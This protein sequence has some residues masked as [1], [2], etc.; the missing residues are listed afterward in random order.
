M[1]KLLSLLAI[2]FVLTA[3]CLNTNYVFS[4]INFISKVKSNLKTNLKRNQQKLNSLLYSNHNNEFENSLVPNSNGFELTNYNSVF[5]KSLAYDSTNLKLTSTL[6]NL[7]NYD[8]K[9]HVSKTDIYLDKVDYLKMHSIVSKDK[10]ETLI[11][12][13]LVFLNHFYNDQSVGFNPNGYIASRR[14]LLKTNS[15]DLKTQSVLVLQNLQKYVKDTLHTANNNHL[16]KTNT[17][18]KLSIG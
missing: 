7:I 8:S 10:K 3:S 11:G 12:N 6:S 14:S 5:L 13:N 17:V 15:T 1:K 4:T 18:S 2:G 16:N 9:H